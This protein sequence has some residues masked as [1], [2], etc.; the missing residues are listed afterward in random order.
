[1]KPLILF[2]FLSSF[3][4]PAQ[5]QKDG[6]IFLTEAL[7]RIPGPA[8]ERFS[9]EF[10]GKEITAYLYIPKTR[11]DQKPHTRDELY[12]IIS[13]NGTFFNGKETLHFAP[14]DI[15]VVPALAEHRF[16]TFSPDFKTWAIFYGP[17]K[18]N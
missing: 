16:D 5:S 13:G 6:Q 15:L 18:K 3:A 14:G 10:D 9:K 8:N 7:S 17:E 2:L 12:I 1:M 4:S 11:D